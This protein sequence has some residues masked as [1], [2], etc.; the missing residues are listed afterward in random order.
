M[1]RLWLAAIWFC[2]SVTLA[3]AAAAGPVP[4]TGR[5]LTEDHSTVIQIA[6][7][8]A[9][10]CGAIVGM[11]SL[12]QNPPTGA[13]QCG[14][15]ILQFAAIPQDDGTIKYR[16]TVTDPRDGNVY[17]ATIGVDSG[18]QLHLHGWI[19]LPFLGQTQIW[20]HY[21]GRTLAD[22]KLVNL[23]PLPNQLGG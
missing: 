1:L 2:G 22:C 21:A 5:W 18:Q 15:I 23:A 16:G 20:T 6:P 7:C 17:Q 8:G 13:A 3:N 4:P 10:L 12:S 19:F 9:E 14:Q 11:A